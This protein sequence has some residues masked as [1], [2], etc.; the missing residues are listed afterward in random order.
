MLLTRCSSYQRFSSFW[1][2]R[3]LLLNPISRLSITSQKQFFSSET[4]PDKAALATHEKNNSRDKQRYK[5]REQPLNTKEESKRGDN[6]NHKHIQSTR[7]F[8]SNRQNN[9]ELETPSTTTATSTKLKYG[10]NIIVES[11]K[12]PYPT[13]H[14]LAPYIQH[15]IKNYKS[16]IR[17]DQSFNIIFLGT[18]GGGRSNH[19]R[20]AS[21]TALRINGSTFIFDV[22]EGTCKQLFFSK[23]G[24]A[25]IKKIFITHLH[26]DHICGL[27][28]V[29]LNIQLAH[30]IE[31]DFVLEIYGPVGLYNYIA[32][33]IAL[34]YCKLILK[35][36]VYE[37]VDENDKGSTH[38]NDNNNG[39]ENNKKRR[40]YQQKR[41]KIFQHTYY[42]TSNPNLKRCYLYPNKTT[43]TWTIQESNNTKDDSKISKDLPTRNLHKKVHIKAARIT[44]VPNVPTFGYVIEEPKPSPKINVQE[45]TR[46][47]LKPGPKY[48]FLKAG[49]SVLNDDKNVLIHPEQVLYHDD[50]YMTKGRK[51]ALIGDNCMVPKS[52]LDISQNCDVLVHEATL[53]KGNEDVVMQR[54]HSTAVMAGEVAKK[55]SAKVL[56]MNHISSKNDDQESIDELVK[57]AEDGCNGVCSVAVAYDFMDF[58]IPRNGFENLK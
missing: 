44:H 5:Q 38:H 50:E 36:N 46:L 1:I 37:L 21:S 13:N 30:N 18:N 20:N 45:A 55:V 17:T 42:E 41:D 57:S 16:K 6:Y 23:L 7:S 47:G 27:L 24:I 58:G 29:I 54:G 2:Q 14:P 8:K 34:T 25:D 3:K 52:M 4:K 33:N 51:F 12:L 43:K 39:Y 10:T 40:T 28:S 31:N 26:A 53:T 19:Q 11:S 48:R 32:M 49:K 9:K 56:L 15:C 22:G 35:I